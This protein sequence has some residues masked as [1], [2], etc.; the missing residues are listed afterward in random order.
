[1]YDPVLKLP[2]VKDLPGQFR[3]LE[4]SS[5]C[6]ERECQ[7]VGTKEFKKNSN[8]IRKR[9]PSVRQGET[10]RKMGGDTF[11]PSGSTKRTHGKKVSHN[12]IAECKTIVFHREYMSVKERSHEIREKG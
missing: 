11:I 7:R 2:P 3:R 1:M 9:T 8:A 6:F 10:W 12:G 5:V 4:W